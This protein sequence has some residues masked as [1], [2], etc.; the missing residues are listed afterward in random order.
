MNIFLLGVAASI[1]AEVISWVSKKIEGTPFKGDGAQIVIL[2]VSFV[3]A[4]VKVL[5]GGYQV[6]D[7]PTLLVFFSQVYA[8]SQIYFLFIGQWYE[9]KSKE[10]LLQ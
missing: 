5:T 4:I 1:L 7:F 8:V 10:S 6:V 3:G 2:I 9:V